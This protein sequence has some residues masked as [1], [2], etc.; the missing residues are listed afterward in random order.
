MIIGGVTYA[1]AVASNLRPEPVIQV[2]AN[3]AGEENSVTIGQYEEGICMMK[4][5]EVAIVRLKDEEIVEG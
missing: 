5:N 3:L 2:I 1:C 4:Y